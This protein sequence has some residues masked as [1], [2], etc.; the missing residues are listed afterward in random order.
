MI[1]LWVLLLKN[2]KVTQQSRLGVWLIAII[3]LDC[4]YLFFYVLSKGFLEARYDPDDWVCLIIELF[5]NL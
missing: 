3:S 5:P 1:L 2:G 4:S